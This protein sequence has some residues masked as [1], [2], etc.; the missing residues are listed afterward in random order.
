MRISNI[1]LAAATFAMLFMGAVFLGVSPEDEN[2][3]SGHE[4]ETGLG[5]T[6]D[7]DQT[8]SIER[9]SADKAPGKIRDD[10]IKTIHMAPNL[11]FSG[12]TSHIMPQRFPGLAQY[13]SAA[14]GRNAST[15]NLTV[16]DADLCAYHP[17]VA[18]Y[19]RTFPRFA[20]SITVLWWD[21]DKIQ[22]NNPGLLEIESAKVVLSPSSSQPD[23]LPVAMHAI[24]TECDEPDM[25]TGV[26]Y[27]PDPYNGPKYLRYDEQVLAQASPTQQGQRYIWDIT[28]LAEKWFTGKFPNYGVMLRTVGSISPGEIIETQLNNQLSG[29]GADAPTPCIELT[30]KENIPPV[31][32][33]EAVDPIQPV[34]GI[35]FTLTSSAS[36]PDGHGISSYVWEFDYGSI[37]NEASIDVTLPE[38]VYRFSL[39]VWDGHPTKSV[40]STTVYKTI[41]VISA[42]ESEAPRIL[43]LKASSEGVTGDS[44]SSGPPI[45]LV[46]EELHHTAGYDG[47]V[48]IIGEDPKDPIVINQAPLTD[49]GDGYYTYSWD[50]AAAPTGKYQIDTTL[51]NPITGL[52]DYDGTR[53]G[54]DLEIDIEDDIAPSVDSVVLMGI[55]EG[56]AQ[57]GDELTI[58]I[59]EKGGEEGCTGGVKISGPGGNQNLELKEVGSGLYRLVW[60]TTGLAQGDY[61][62]D[63][64]LSDVSG[65]MDE[66]GVDGSDPDVSF[67]IRDTEAPTVIS[68]GVEMDDSGWVTVWVL[69]GSGEEGL[70]GAVYL[71]GPEGS[72]LEQYLTDSGE[73]LYSAE[74]DPTDM[75]EIYYDVTVTLEDSN[76][77]MD[78]DG[79]DKHP[80]T[81]FYTIPVK[82]NPP[83]V[84]SHTPAQME[85]IND[86]SA[87]VTVTFSEPVNTEE[88]LEDVIIVVDSSGEQV[89]GTVVMTADRDEISFSPKN[90]WAHGESYV[91]VVMPVLAN[92]ESAPMVQFVSWRFAVEGLIPPEVT[93]EDPE[94]DPL[95]TAGT[96]IEF[97]AE[98]DNVET[99]VWKVDGE[100]VQ[101][102][103]GTAYNYT[104]TDPGIHVVEATGRSA[105]GE[106]SLAWFINVEK[107]PEDPTGDDSGGSHG[108]SDEGSS[109]F[110][111][112]NAV[113]GVI[114]ALLI[115]VFVIL[116]IMAK[117]KKGQDGTDKT[118]PAARGGPVPG[119]KVVK[120]DA[121]IQNNPPQGPGARSTVMKGT[122]NTPGSQSGTP[123]SQSGT[124]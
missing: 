30:F 6:G 80:D 56:L 35:P 29:Q 14:Y 115:V 58:L 10:G 107:A 121:S 95:I 83:L 66:D 63:V 123:G 53:P 119:I 73:G 31:A 69:E 78:M 112:I 106:T 46:L 101:S 48:T 2:T 109:S 77:N 16:G 124:R 70:D 102:G 91:V 34:E 99:I 15:A 103:K 42:A 68:V 44:F 94:N 75:E 11:A 96:P 50:T 33:I 89:K 110:G 38:G 59:Q 49:R 32:S 37:G 51:V 88:D 81:M 26:R 74:F 39:T 71:T 27:L 108:S 57:P 12:D 117:G 60:D 28:S 86:L 20:K 93:E 5:N 36:D 114:L 111:T 43:D 120:K 18:D 64:W 72:E 17:E 40:N 7:A 45:D 85:I 52:G 104:P 87:P 8:E 3:H 47:R 61:T 24:T 98:F 84:T 54:P 55:Q 97:T 19:S 25:G 92:D 118:A 1:V 62:V 100:Q 105:G 21:V 9:L 79:L 90:L 116:L 23:L 65:N 122:S 4:M 41:T 13:A 76:G 82:G 22:E 67:S 113:L